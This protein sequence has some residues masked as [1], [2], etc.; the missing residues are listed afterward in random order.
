[1]SRNE[2]RPFDEVVPFNMVVPVAADTDAPLMALLSV[3]AKTKMF[4]LPEGFLTILMFTVCSEVPMMFTKVF[5]VTWP[6][7]TARIE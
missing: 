1:M 2:T 4:R 5:D 7:A 3:L 6:V